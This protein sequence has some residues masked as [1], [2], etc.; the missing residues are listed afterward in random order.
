[1]SLLACNCLEMEEL[2]LININEE[3]N[4]VEDAQVVVYRNPKIYLERKNPLLIY[5]NAQFRKK[6]RMRKEVA[7]FIINLIRDEISNPENN[8]GSPISAEVQVL[9][10]VRYLAKGA[11]GDDIGR[12]FFNGLHLQL[13]TTKAA[14]V[15]IAVLHNIIVNDRLEN[16][17]HQNQE[18]EAD[19]EADDDIVNPIDNNRQG[20]I[21]RQEY[22][23]HHF[24]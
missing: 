21:Y 1:M 11:Y 3:V 22:I 20:N 18:E 24:N 23:N 8:R 4:E 16:E 12:C 17:D 6:Y 15:A 5:D 2:G 7:E 19:V 9:A 10:T 13:E 14:I